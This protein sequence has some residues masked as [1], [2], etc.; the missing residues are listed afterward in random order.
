MKRG[1][2]T[3]RFGDQGSIFAKVESSY[4]HQCL[5]SGPITDWSTN[6]SA[7][8]KIILGDRSFMPVVS[9]SRVLLSI[10]PDKLDIGIGKEWGSTPSSL[11]YAAIAFH[12]FGLRLRCHAYSTRTCRR[13]RAAITK[14]WRRSCHA[15][16]LV[17]TT[18]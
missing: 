3:S 8:I 18:L 7:L 4:D 1:T 6:E 11:L 17:F 15:T 12:H 10:N 2:G 9:Q 13:A 5:K 16:F 14:K